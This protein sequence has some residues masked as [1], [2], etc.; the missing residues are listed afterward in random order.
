MLGVII[1]RLSRRHPRLAFEV[2]LGGDMAD[3]PH[4]ALRDRAIDLIIG[5]LPGQIPI[6]MEAITLYDDKLSIV[7]A[8]QNPLTRRRK[9]KLAELLEE[10]WCGP[11]FDD[12]PWSLVAAAFRAEG[13]P[14]PRNVVRV[15]DILARDG[16]LA[17]GRFL[18]ILPRTVLHFSAKRLSLKPVPVALEIPTFPVGIVTLKNRTLNP[19]A[20]VFIECA[21]EIAKPLAE[22][23][24]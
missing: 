20:Q 12:F 19:V 3:L 13:L 23:S 9:V 15:R 2:T 24:V 21:R 8:A 11:S 6:D 18:T 17:T 22:W 16:L 14:V 10:L 1:D 4:R 7:A 5:R